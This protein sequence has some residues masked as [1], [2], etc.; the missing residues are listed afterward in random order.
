MHKQLI[1]VSM[2]ILLPFSSEIF[3]GKLETELAWAGLMPKFWRKYVDYPCAIIRK[4]EVENTLKGQLQFLN[5]KLRK[6]K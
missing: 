4:N 6:K 3:V 5:V 2:G 1:G